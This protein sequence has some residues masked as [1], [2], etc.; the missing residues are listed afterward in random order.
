MFGG[1]DTSRAF[2]VC[3]LQYIVNNRCGGLGC[4]HRD[5][6]LEQPVLELMLK[7]KLPFTRSFVCVTIS[8]RALNIATGKAILLKAETNI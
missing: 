1:W 8:L 4:I 3:G 6:Y 2:I 5:R 7:I